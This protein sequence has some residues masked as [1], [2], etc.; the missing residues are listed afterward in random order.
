[1][2]KEQGFGVVEAERRPPGFTTKRRNDNKLTSGRQMHVRAESAGHHTN[3]M[4]SFGG[5]QI[6]PVSSRLK[7]ICEKINQAVKIY[8]EPVKAAASGKR[9]TDQK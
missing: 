5:G 3:I 4:F 1:L 2:W 7:S 8:A 6:C 9:P